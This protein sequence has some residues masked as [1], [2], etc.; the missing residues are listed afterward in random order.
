MSTAVLPAPPTGA[1]TGRPG[2]G[3]LTLVELRKMSDTRA[4]FWLLVSTALLTIAACVIAGLA[5]PDEDAT[6]VNFFA[7]ALTPPSVLLPVMG[8]LL[9]TSEW[10]QRTAM[11]TFS[12]VPHR[13][14]VLT[15][16]LLA[17]LALTTVAFQLCL[18]VALL[19]TA[20]AGGGGDDTWSLSAG[21]IGQAA[22]SIGIPMITGI[23][24]GA[25][26]LASA[27]AIVLYFVLPTAFGILGSFSALEG[28]ARWVDQ[29]RTMGKLVEETYGGTEWARLLVSC[30]LWT[31]LPLVIG[32]LRVLRS[33]V[34]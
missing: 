9:V 17:G 31:L 8:I 1:A 19:T 2:L 10:S 32:W 30:A 22:V 13:G 28:V 27:P 26:L 21:L 25:A 14:R 5:L 20:V 24:F 15:A 6:L 3:R 12:L 16:K 18:V 29:S 23:G 7:I 33:D 11:V 4:G 34:R